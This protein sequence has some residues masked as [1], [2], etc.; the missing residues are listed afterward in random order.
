MASERVEVQMYRLEKKD[1]LSFLAVI[2][3]LASFWLN[4]DVLAS[5]TNPSLNLNK[6]VALLENRYF[7]RTYTN[8]PITKRIERLELL[9]FAQTQAGDDITRFNRLKDAV[10]KR[11]Q[12]PLPAEA[13]KQDSTNNNKTDSVYNYP[14]LNTLEWKA[15]KKTFAGESL[16]KRLERLESKLFGQPSQTMA[17]IDRVDRIKRTLGIGVDLGPQSP[18]SAKLPKQLGPMPKA[19]PRSSFSDDMNLYNPFIGSAPNNNE[20]DYFG[21]PQGMNSE[22]ARMFSDMNKQMQLLRKLGPGSW[23][24]NNQTQTWEKLDGNDNGQRGQ[25]GENPNQF[26]KKF[27]APEMQELPPYADPNSI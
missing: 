20:F 7:S 4:A 23:R 26:F 17:Y 12:S 18:F 3:I 27:K 6:S 19:K 14:V 5:N 2:A 22:F 8:D 15:F 25:P 24:Y 21:M 13:N 10:A 9:V 11:S 16:D 1:I